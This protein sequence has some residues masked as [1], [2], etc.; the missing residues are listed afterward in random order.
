MFDIDK[1]QEIFIT[2]TKNRTRSI[3]TAFGVFWGVFMLVI[4]SGVGYG[5]KNGMLSNLKDFK[6]NSCFIFSNRT[7]IPYKGYS[8]GRRWDLENGDIEAIKANI[9]EVE[10]VSGV[11]F[12]GQ[13]TNNVTRGDK[14]G[15]FETTGYS[16]DYCKIDPQT[17]LFGRYINEVDV[18]NKRRVCVIGVTVHEK[19]FGKLTDPIGE[20]LYIKG[21][22]YTVIGV[23]KATSNIS[24]GGD[25]ETTIILP[26]STMQQS[27]KYGEIMHGLAL[28][29]NE[30][31][32]ISEIEPKITALLRQRHSI[33]PNDIAAINRFN[34]AEQFA[35]FNNL[36]LGV[37]ILIWI[38]GGSTL[39]AGVIGV[40]NIMLVSVKERTKEIGIK[41]A[42]GAKPINIVTQIVS[43][44]TVLTSL[45]G[46]LGLGFSVAVLELVGFVMKSTQATTESDMTFF[47]EPQIPF[48]LAVIATIVIVL[49][50]IAAG[51][52]PASR[53]INIKAIDAI[54]EE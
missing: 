35:M 53:A 42:L 21:I 31:A 45:S 46:M 10:I 1:W 52:L 28:A 18:I 24:L 26:L 36:F 2:I 54:R 22:P 51:L 9:P 16:A 11:L 14:Y 4:M 27:L 25:S 17:M 43:E 32:P 30:N 3:L 33:A 44:S 7:T 47:S 23:N 50:G 8:P 38:V 34:L 6:Q 41:R 49:S 48:G 29:V 37:S 12:G 15:S 5:F 20:L 40:T 19:M 39:L 13:T